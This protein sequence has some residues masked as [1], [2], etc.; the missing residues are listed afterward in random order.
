VLYATTFFMGAGISIMQPA[1]PRVV[2]EW[3]PERVAFGT[4]VYSNGLLV[5]NLVAA[6]LTVPI[7]LPLAGGSWR[8]GLLFWSLPVFATA[9]L[10]AAR[11]PRATGLATSSVPPSG[12]SPN[13]RNPL[14]WRLGFILGCVNSL[15]FG[16]NFFLPDYLHHTNQAHLITSALAALNLCQMPA[17]FLLLVLVGRLAPWSWSYVISGALAVAGIL[18]LLIARN[19]LVVVASS[20]LLGFVA[21]ALLIL[22]LA[23]PPLL[24]KPD[25]VHRV[26]AGIFTISYSC[27]VVVPI[28][29][30]LI[31]DAT[32]IA[33]SVFL[34]LGLCA[35]SIIVLSF[36]LRLRHHSI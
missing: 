23:L 6:W 20:G 25:E 4:A 9:L 21:T 2:R 13:W 7:I 36:G 14:I 22:I 12:W 35:V 10:V 1:L 26:S 27:A 8:L 32:G 33:W 11:G 19:P 34:P 15:Y 24:A 5:G 3:L 29:S 28:V 30:G 17:S 31:W 16:T 18:G